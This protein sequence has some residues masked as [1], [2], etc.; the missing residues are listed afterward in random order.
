VNG[1]RV[2]YFAFDLTHSNLPI[3]VGFPI[4]GAR[5][6]EWL[7]GT[8]A[9]AVSSEP[10]GTPIPL[11]VQAGGTARLTL[12]GGEIRD[13]TP[14]AA[15]FTETGRP[16]VYRLEYLTAD[17]IV[18]PGAVA[19]RT[20]V[21]D[22][23]A[24]ASRALATSGSVTQA[25]EVSMLVREWAPWVIGAVLLLMAIEW[26]VGHQRPGLARRQATI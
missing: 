12:P 4:L 17:G 24:G 16:G 26:W 1:H 19:V 10:A 13:L 22:E 25:D 14:G 23:S 20:F 8:G 5:I 15:S 18:T 21:A 3:Q 7:G 6:L 2:A 11:A 9:G